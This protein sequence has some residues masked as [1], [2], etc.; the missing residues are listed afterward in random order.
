[1]ILPSRRALMERGRSGKFLTT[2]AVIIALGPLLGP[3][4]FLFLLVALALIVIIG[5]G[6]S[7]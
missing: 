1:M 4:G 2:L 7:A 3:I 6:L 5:W